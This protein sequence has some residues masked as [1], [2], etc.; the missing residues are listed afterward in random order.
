MKSI[1]AAET[2]KCLN[3]MKELLAKQ[4]QNKEEISRVQLPCTFN[5]KNNKICTEYV[6]MF[7]FSMKKWSNKSYISTHRGMHTG[8]RPMPL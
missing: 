3:S 5:E 6:E 1:I 4:G 7:E 8:K 2:E